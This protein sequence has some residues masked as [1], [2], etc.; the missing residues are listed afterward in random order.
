MSD[1][2]HVKTDKILDE[3]ISDIDEFFSPD[4]NRFD[5]FNSVAKKINLYSFSAEGIEQFTQTQRLKQAKKDDYYDIL[6]ALIVAFLEESALKSLDEISER[7]KDVYKLNYKEFSDSIPEIDI[8]K[9]KIEKIKKEF[10]E[11]VKK[12]IE[13]AI[14]QGRLPSDILLDIKREIRKHKNIFLRISRT[15]VTQY[16]N[17]ARYEAMNFV[18]VKHKRWITQRDKRVR[19]SHK[20]LDGETRPIDDRFSNGLLYPGDPDGDVSERA[21]CRCF[22]QAVKNAAL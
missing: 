17:M 14:K 7:V 18:G 1:K 12:R 10:S 8:P 13:T 22:I 6:I 3:L 2:A 16:E 15:L 5:E 19:D 20:R 11:S 21:N 4:S 9:F